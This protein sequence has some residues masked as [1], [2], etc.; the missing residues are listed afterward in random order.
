MKGGEWTER[1][2]MANTLLQGLR[3]EAMGLWD[4]AGGRRNGETAHT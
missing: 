4:F 3:E 2:E 1:R